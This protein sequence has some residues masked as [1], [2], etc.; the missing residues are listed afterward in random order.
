MASSEQEKPTAS[1]METESAGPPQLKRIF[2]DEEDRTLDKSK[3]VKLDLNVLGDKK[4]ILKYIMDL[5]ITTCKAVGLD[6][7]VLYQEIPSMQV[8][9]VAF[10][11]HQVKRMSLTK[12]ESARLKN[13]KENIQNY[14]IMGKNVT[15]A[16]S[17]LLAVWENMAFKT[18][19][20]VDIIAKAH[21]MMCL[22]ELFRERIREL[23]VGPD[24]FVVSKNKDTNEIKQ[25][26][27]STLGV[28]V[29][30]RHM[31][32]GIGWD[33]QVRGTLS[34]YTSTLC[35]AAILSN[36]KKDQYSE[37]VRVSVE[38]GY[39]FVPN[40]KKISEFIEKNSIG[41]NKP[42]LTKLSLISAIHGDKSKRRASFPVSFLFKHCSS[43]QAVEGQS[44]INYMPDKFDDFGFSSKKAALIYSIHGKEM[45]I[46]KVD[47]A[48]ARQ[49]LFHAIFGTGSEDH[50]ILSKITNEAKFLTR[51]SFDADFFKSFFGSSEIIKV[52]GV[53]LIYF[54]K[55]VEASQCRWLN[56]G[57]ESYGSYS[58]FSGFRI[59]SFSESFNEFIS[60]S[61]ARGDSVRL[62]DV[63]TVVKSLDKT[64]TLLSKKIK[65]SQ[66][67]KKDIIF[68]TTKW[69]K[70]ETAGF[71]KD[72]PGE[73]IEEKFSETGITFW[74]N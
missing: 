11:V 70:V 64:L 66:D 40:I 30:V 23:R 21:T 18:E 54:A 8:F 26:T 27:C 32:T 46:P 19:Y 62:D 68:G 61:E 29:N 72:L 47:K 65:E 6:F 52:D 58:A 28:P 38:R 37:K 4:I 69:R 41:T 35:Q 5:C 42:V 16:G 34:K 25:R 53:K 15:M 71:G 10:C 2:L 74:S 57:T 43:V 73:E 9:H 7:S 31:L 3:K 13:I 48:K 36:N 45:V 1:T 14:V 56:T 67:S 50:G 39:G 59:K 22:F 51:E 49:I 44:T 55:S 17:D 33:L 60:S 24:V 63:T 20:P 12:T